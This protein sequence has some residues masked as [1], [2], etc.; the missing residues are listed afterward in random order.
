MWGL[1]LWELLHSWLNDD[2]VNT[3]WYDFM[4]LIKWHQY[5]FVY[6]LTLL[7]MYRA[8]S[9]YGWTLLMIH[10]KICSKSD[11]STRKQLFLILYFSVHIL[12]GLFLCHF[13]QWT[14]CFLDIFLYIIVISQWNLH[15]HFKMMLLTILVFIRFTA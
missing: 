5:A 10:S 9:T 6:Y 7:V 8:S 12:R 2:Y 13:I 11:I 14:C 1:F 3:C 4:K 15:K